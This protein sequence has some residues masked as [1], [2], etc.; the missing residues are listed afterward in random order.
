[1]QWCKYLCSKTGGIYL[2]PNMDEPSVSGLTPREFMLAYDIMSNYTYPSERIYA[3]LAYDGAW[4]VAI[5]L[6]MTLREMEMQ[7]EL[8]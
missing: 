8:G 4:A 3:P 5:A 6:N 1:M 2:N 7:G